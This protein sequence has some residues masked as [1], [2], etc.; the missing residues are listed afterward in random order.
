MITTRQIE[1]KDFTPIYLPVTKAEFDYCRECAYKMKNMQPTY[2]NGKLV[3]TDYQASLTNFA[4][5]AVATTGAIGEFKAYQWLTGKDIEWDYSKPDNGWDFEL[6]DKKF[7][8][9]TAMSLKYEMTEKETYTDGKVIPVTTDYYIMGYITGY[10]TI[11]NSVNFY[12]ECDRKGNL[13]W[14]DDIEWVD[15]MCVIIMAV[16]D[17][18]KLPSGSWRV[19]K[20]DKDSRVDRI[21]CW[22]CGDMNPAKALHKFKTP[23]WKKRQI[24]SFVNG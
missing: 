22:S 18:Y 15:G 12:G 17:V 11:Q 24:G 4:K 9:K 2:K 23:A 6:S 1:H 19:K 16:A 8:M 13:V 14:R 10:D 5:I 20:N 3:M 21:L 7:D